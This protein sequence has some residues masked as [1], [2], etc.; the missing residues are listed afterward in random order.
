[1]ICGT[2]PTHIF[3]IPFDT[4]I[5]KEALVVYVQGGSEIVRKETDDCSMEGKQIGVELTQEETLSFNPNMNV[6]IQIRV[7]TTEGVAYASRPCV[8][9]VVKCLTDEVI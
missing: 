6:E 9:S 1:M 5:V 8:V 3:E 7:L 4:A 2:T